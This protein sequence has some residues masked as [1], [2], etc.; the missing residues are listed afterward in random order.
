VAPPAELLPVALP[1]L[2]AARVASD[3]PYVGLKETFL[4]SRFESGH[5]EFWTHGRRWTGAPGSVIVFE[6]G[7]VHR[8]LKRDGRVTY[9]LIGFSTPAIDGVRAQSCLAADDVR[10]LPFQ[11]LHNAVAARADRFALEC[12]L[13]EAIAALGA[14]T[15]SR[16]E[17]TRPVRRALALLRE[18]FAE[19][20][21]LDELSAHAGLDKFHLCR[22]FRAQ[23]GMPPHAY[24]TQLRILSAKE[25]LAAG[26]KPKDVAGQVGMYDQ[27]Q[28]NRHFRR[29]VGVTPGQYSAKN[30]QSFVAV[31]P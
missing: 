22:A 27:S 18:R 21:T 4:I 30:R 8:D 11:R 2:R 15:D 14:T 25:L 28:L 9:Q 13:A 12:A 5:S 26:A 19:A 3:E 20:L 10:G 1:G 16:F 24:L 23:V 17:P 29:L 6:P 31:G 7:D